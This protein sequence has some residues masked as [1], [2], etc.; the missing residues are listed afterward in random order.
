M[1]TDSH[2]NGGV[3]GTMARPRTNIYCAQPPTPSQRYV[4]EQA[5]AQHHACVMLPYRVDT[6]VHDGRILAEREIFLS[7]RL[8]INI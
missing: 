4:K 6:L 8:P 5:A 7:S 2:S 3:Y 1:D